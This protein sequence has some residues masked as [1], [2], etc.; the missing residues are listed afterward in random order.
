LHKDIVEKQLLRIKRSNEDNVNVKT[1][2]HREK[3]QFCWQIFEKPD[4]CD[5]LAMA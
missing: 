4:V 3:S 5:S 1:S 2:D